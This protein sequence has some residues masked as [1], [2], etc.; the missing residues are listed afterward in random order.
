MGSQKDE[1]LSFPLNP[2]S[3]ML[4]LFCFQSILHTIPKQSYTFL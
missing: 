1:K 3:I 2:I 4:N